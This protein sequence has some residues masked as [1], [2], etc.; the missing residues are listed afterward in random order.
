MESVSEPRL[1]QLETSTHATASSDMTMIQQMTSQI[2]HSIF[3]TK[4][5]LGPLKKFA[6]IPRFF[7]ETNYLY[8]VQ[9]N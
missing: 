4:S 1:E 3:K 2:V 9:E 8:L 5:T 7:W 6:S